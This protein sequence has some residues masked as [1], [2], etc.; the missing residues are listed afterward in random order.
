M[1]KSWFLLSHSVR[2]DSF[3]IPLTAACQASLSFTVSWS[4][5][6]LMSNE[7]V[8]PSNHL[9]LCHPLLLLPSVFPSIRGFSSESALGGNGQSIA[10]T[11][12]VLPVNIQGWFPSG[13]TGWVSMQ[14]NGLSR[15]FS[16]TTVHKHQ[17]FGAQPSSQSNSH[18]HT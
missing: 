9:L 2:S 4:L 17:F 1:P 5:V 3:G 15:V 7:S 14:S 8:M 12:S 11:A 6:K 13:L 10:V 18:I 16:N